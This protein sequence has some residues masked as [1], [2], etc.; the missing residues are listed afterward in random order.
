VD[1]LKPKVAAA[2]SVDSDFVVGEFNSVS[3]SGKP[4]VTDVFGQALVRLPV[5][6]T[7]EYR[8]MGTQWVADTSLHAAS[9]NISKV[10]LH[11]V[12]LMYECLVLVI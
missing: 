2:L 12:G 11:Q 9:I 3:C 7:S 5:W 10:F 1:I 8:S 6:F 4:N